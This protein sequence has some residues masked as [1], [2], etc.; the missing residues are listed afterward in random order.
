MIGL[1]NFNSKFGDLMSF[2]FGDG[3][4]QS[5]SCMHVVEHVGL[6]RYGDSQDYDGDVKAIAELKRIVKSGGDLLLVVPVGAPEI[7]FN[8][9]RI[10]SYAQMLGNFEGFEPKEFSLIT[11]FGSPEGMVENAPPGLVCQQEYGCSCFWF[12]K[13]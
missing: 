1:V 12:R 10:Y 9:H 3:E 7:V 5:V 2:P 6:G 11:D 4:L 13:S 8:A